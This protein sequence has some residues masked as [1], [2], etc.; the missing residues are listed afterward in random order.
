MRML[1]R[2]TSK[3]N[4]H[5]IPL[6][7]SIIAVVLIFAHD[8]FNEYDGAWY[9]LSGR[10][11]LSTGEYSGWGSNFWPPLGSFIFG[12]GDLFMPGFL[13]GKYIALLSGLGIL[14][15]S[16]YFGE[17]LFKRKNSGIF[18]QAVVVSHPLMILHSFRVENHIIDAFFVLGALFF[19]YKFTQCPRNYYILFSAIFG[20]FASLTRYTSLII[21]PVAIFI[22]WYRIFE[23]NWELNSKIIQSVLYSLLFTTIF[24]LIQSP[25]LLFNYHQNGSP[26]H[27]WQY[28]NI[29]KAV[30]P[31]EG[32][33][34]WWSK[35][36]GYNGIFD[37]IRRHPIN[38]IGNFMNNILSSAYYV[39]TRSGFLVLGFVFVILKTIFNIKDY[40]YMI[41]VLFGG[42]YILLV[43][44]AFVFSSL[45]VH[46]SIYI[47]ILSTGFIIFVEKISLLHKKGVSSKRIVLVIFI[48]NMSLVVPFAVEILDR[49][50]RD[51]GHMVDAPEL[52][53]QLIEY[54][55]D[56]DEKY[57]M[58][59]NPALAYYHGGN[60]MDFPSF[61]QGNLSQML[62]YNGVSGPVKTYAYSKAIPPKNTDQKL[63][64]DYLVLNPWAEKKH[65]NYRYLVDPENSTIPDGF[66]LVYSSKEVVVYDVQDHTQSNC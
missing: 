24:F 38:Y 57:V 66:K 47:A 46:L 32:S 62:C 13:S 22:I 11:M 6:I 18:T 5:L 31:T 16:Y 1:S 27:T 55:E 59:G 58:S 36:A 51:N 60:H 15:I 44:Q 63:S 35:Q 17:D 42:G 43:S 49:D 26:F 4:I 65:P 61:Y 20:G 41:L 37:I 3:I 21:G 40:R 2:F 54:D 56:L 45:L 10:Q 28:L 30:V 52:S 23:N 53:E 19:L 8:R 25:W 12:T 29:G 64:A 7:Y 39:I 33:S 34:W 48:L 14:Y 9:L 50:A